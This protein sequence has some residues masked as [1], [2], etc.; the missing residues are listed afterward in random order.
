MCVASVLCLYTCSDRWWPDLRYD[1]M[2]N[3]SSMVSVVESCLDIHGNP[4]PDIIFLDFNLPHIRRKWPRHHSS[5][6]ISQV[7]AQINSCTKGN[8]DGMPAS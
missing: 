1:N 3:L 2:S 7:A 4:A 5:T 6:R 8:F